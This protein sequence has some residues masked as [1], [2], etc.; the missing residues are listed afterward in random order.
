[1]SVYDLPTLATQM[2]DAFKARTN[3]AP[4]IIGLFFDPLT[5]PSREQ[6]QTGESTKALA[7]KKLLQQVEHFVEYLKKEGVVE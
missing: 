4:V 7:R 3:G 5:Y 1:M 6:Y 2:S